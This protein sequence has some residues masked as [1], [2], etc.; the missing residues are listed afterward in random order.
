MGRVRNWRE[1]GGCSLGEKMDGQV[2]RVRVYDTEYILN[3][4]TY[5]ASGQQA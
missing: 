1:V 3:F 2:A 4:D 5:L